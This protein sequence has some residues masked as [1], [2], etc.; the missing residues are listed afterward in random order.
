MLC[1]SLYNGDIM[2]YLS[3]CEKCEDGESVAG[4]ISIF[5]S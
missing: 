3:L 5:I 1:L 4:L 2:L